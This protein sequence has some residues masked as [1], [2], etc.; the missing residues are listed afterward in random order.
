[1]RDQARTCS[2]FQRPVSCGEMRPS[3]L[4]AVA[5]LTMRPAPPMAKA[6][7]CTRCQSVGTPSRSSTEYWQSA[8]TQRRLRKV[9]ER[10]LSGLKRVEEVTETSSRSGAAVFPG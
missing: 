7:R 9:V 8:G 5:S 1:M 10:M 2:S 3:G 4:T 6:P